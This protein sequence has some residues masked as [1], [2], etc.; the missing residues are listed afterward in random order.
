MVES[1]MS[2]SNNIALIIVIG[3]VVIGFIILLIVIFNS[4]NNS[5]NNN[6]SESN[7]KDD[8]DDNNNNIPNSGRPTSVNN[9]VDKVTKQNN[10]IE[11]RQNVNIEPKYTQQLPIPSSHINNTNESIMEKPEV[12]SVIEQPMKYDAPQENQQMVYPPVL[13][14]AT[15]NN[16]SSDPVISGES[17]QIISDGA[18]GSSVELTSQ[19]KE[20]GISLSKESDKSF[21]PKLS[22]ENSETSSINLSN[23]GTSSINLNN[24]ET[25]SI[26]LNNSET[27]SINL[28]NSETSSINSNNTSSTI[29]L[30][31]S[32]SNS[33]NLN[34][35][36]SEGLE[37]EKRAREEQLASVEEISYPSLSNSSSN[38]S[39][40][41][42]PSLKMPV[43]PVM[44]DLTM[45]KSIKSD[46]TNSEIN[47]SNDN[48]TVGLSVDQ[49][50]SDPAS[51]S[52]NF[53]SQTDKSSR[54][55]NTKI[56]EL[57]KLKKNNP[58][59]GPFN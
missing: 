35:N 23:S 48:E 20:S 36:S 28:N 6:S 44:T 4:S 47:Y 3:L 15:Y 10:N 16:S 9:K 52:S 46:M 53:S 14:K 21:S 19:T 49:S 51:F 34:N 43:M 57:I 58:R 41:K 29:D 59:M 12:K 56:N 7:N 42:L 5:S 26:N 13:E 54:S 24:S 39:G 17:S 18:K 55:N 37:I 33:I 30:N 2:S 38:K 25:S 11:S 40:I 31:N 50:I 8:E 1:Q 45:S 22:K 27:S 32:S